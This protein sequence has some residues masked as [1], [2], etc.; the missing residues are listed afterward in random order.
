[1][2]VPPV[3]LM[4]VCVPSTVLDF[5]K[6]TKSILGVGRGQGEEWNRK[7][8]LLDIS[9]IFQNLGKMLFHF[10]YTQGDLVIEGDVS[11][12]NSVSLLTPLKV[13]LKLTYPSSP[14]RK[15]KLSMTEQL[16]EG[17]T[18]R[19]WQNYTGNL[20]WP[21]LIPTPFLM[22]WSCFPKL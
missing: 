10:Q 16:S 15:L 4:C 14:L 11:K 22:T 7:Y 1:M 8:K 5:L 21:T 13:F 12:Y 9:R 2:W 3:C 18:V 19:R 6:M 20:M 17:H